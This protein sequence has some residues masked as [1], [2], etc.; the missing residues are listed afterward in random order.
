MA[1]QAWNWYQR[2]L[3]RNGTQIYFGTFCP[4]KP[5]YLLRI[6][7]APGYSPQDWPSFYFSAKFSRNVLKWLTT[8]ES[9]LQLATFPHTHVHEHWDI[10][11]PFFYDPSRWMSRF[12][13]PHFF[14]R[15]PLSN[16]VA[17][18][19]HAT[20]IFISHDKNTVYC[21][22]NPNYRTINWELSRDK[23]KLPCD[24]SKLSCDKLKIIAQ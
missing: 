7:V 9:Q 20:Y 4:E 11:V 17:H 1:V 23:F 16:T 6:F 13:P 21:A 18:R 3:S 2:W 19:G 8:Y 22:I 10:T 5:D 24:K 12:L 14:C 15:N